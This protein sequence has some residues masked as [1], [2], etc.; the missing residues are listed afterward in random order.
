[1]ILTVLHCLW[2][3]HEKSFS[4][5]YSLLCKIVIEK[6]SNHNKFTQNKRSAKF[7]NNDFS[8]PNRKIWRFWNRR[9]TRIFVKIA[10]LPLSFRTCTLIIIMRFI[11]TLMDPQR[12]PRPPTQIISGSVQIDLICTLV[13]KIYKGN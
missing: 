5:L 2:K 4:L 8:V 9:D 11:K 10:I 3:H 1:M 6:Y 7:Q 13:K 12:L